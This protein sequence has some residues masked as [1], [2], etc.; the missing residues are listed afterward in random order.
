MHVRAALLAVL[1]VAFPPEIEGQQTA[2]HLIFDMDECAANCECQRVACCCGNQCTVSPGT[3]EV[4]YTSCVSVTSSQSTWSCP[5]DE[6]CGIMGVETRIS[7]CVGPDPV[8]AGRATNSGTS[9]APMTF[10]STFPFP[11]T[12][13][14]TGGIWHHN[15]KMGTNIQFNPGAYFAYTNSYVMPEALHQHPDG[16]IDVNNH[17][18]PYYSDFSG[19]VCYGY[20]LPCP[21]GY[22]CA[23]PFGYQAQQTGFC[24]KIPSNAWANPSGGNVGTNRNSHP[25]SE[26]SCASP[27]VCGYKASGGT[28]WCD[29]ACVASN[30]CCSDAY[31]YCSINEQGPPGGPTNN[32]TQYEPEC[33]HA[34]LQGDC[35]GRCG[36]GIVHHAGGKCHCDASC[37]VYNDCCCNY[38]SACSQ[39]LGPG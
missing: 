12:Q 18:Y 26:H 30:D 20:L 34:P 37:F 25:A 22:Y 13:M 8:P 27:S 17:E 32:V 14:V 11:G 5:S 29:D 10:G 7:K 16:T 9:G 15:I 39:H 19:Q 1:L 21:D 35:T 31:L 33:R 3:T 2:C 36:A 38:E 4:R 24:T 6:I 23:V 28:C